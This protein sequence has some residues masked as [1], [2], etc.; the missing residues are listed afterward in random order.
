MR[1][2]HIPLLLKGVVGFFGGP[3]IISFLRTVITLIPKLLTSLLDL[4]IIADDLELFSESYIV[5]AGA[6][7]PPL[8]I[9]ITTLPDL[10]PENAEGAVIYL[11][12]SES[13]LD[14]RDK[15][16]VRLLRNTYL[17][18]INQPGVAEELDSKIEIL[19]V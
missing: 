2:K 15:G 19:I 8:F 3:V 5:Q 17:L 11:R 18:R 10:L 7:L 16:Q 9:Q 12:L 14:E 6:P 13:E 1:C 4:L